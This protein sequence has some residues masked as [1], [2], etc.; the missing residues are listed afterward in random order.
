MAGMIAST[1]G[2][3]V[4]S[5]V[6]L[7]EMTRDYNVILP[8]IL[9]VGV[10]YMVRKVISPASIYTLK[11][12]RRGHVV[13]EGL[14]AARQAAHHA[15]SVMSDNFVVLQAADSLDAW[16][17]SPS[18]T[19]SDP[20]VVVV[21]EGRVVGV[22]PSRPFVLPSESAP[23]NLGAIA[24][25]DY[26]FVSE[27]DSFI[28]VMAAKQSHDAR[29]ALVTRSHSAREAGDIIGVITHDEIALTVRSDARLYR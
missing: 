7:F 11:L 12:L 19:R 16:P 17:V 24:Q 1:T 9:T 18:Q 26:V 22:I 28:E 15:S 2:A 6:M 13:P 14:L 4:T 10:A 21:N 25:S 8:L 20:V 23:P 27:K 29:V 3:L 5:I